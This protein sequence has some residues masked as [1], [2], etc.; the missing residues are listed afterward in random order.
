MSSPK[1]Y[2]HCDY[3]ARKICL[4][5][6]DSKNLIGYFFVDIPAWTKHTQGRDFKE[7]Q[8]LTPEEREI[9]IYDVASK[10]YETM[11]EAVRRYDS[12]HL[13]FGDRYHGNKGIPEGVLRAM[14]PYVDVLSIQYF[15]NG[16]AESHEKMVEDFTKWQ[17]I[18]D[19]PVLNADIGNRCPTKMRPN[20]EGQMPDE[21][22]RGLDYAHSLRGLLKQP[23]F[24]GWHW[25]S[26]LENPI[27]GCG[28][29]DPWDEPYTD[30]IDIVRE[31]NQSAY[32]EVFGD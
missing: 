6:A 24:I 2:E 28:L 17:A 18:A 20:V 12:K 4:E 10:Y 5:H 1:F 14:K 16:T 7:L 22:G 29:K 32:D 8:N 31:F 11:T 27:R 26:Y 13:I 15:C 19:K 25:C 30:M 3:L 23:W 9:K 21:R